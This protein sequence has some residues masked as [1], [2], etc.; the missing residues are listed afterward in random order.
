MPNK[1]LLPVLV[2]EL[3]NLGERIRLA[4]LRR[5]L[6]QEELCERAGISR[7]TLSAIEN[8]ETGVSFLSYVLVLKVMN[9]A[10]DLSAIA[11]DDVLG[12]K[13]QDLNLEKPRV[14]APKR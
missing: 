13:L 4:R 2:K 14:R 5:E 10:K 8:G 3:A 1:L 11:A 9:L 12:R 6:S 7:P